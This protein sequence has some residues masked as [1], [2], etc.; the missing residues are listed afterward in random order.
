MTVEAILFQEKTGINCHAA[1]GGLFQ[2]DLTV[3]S[4]RVNEI[5]VVMVSTFP[6]IGFTENN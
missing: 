4:V 2:T 5:H 3:Y 1:F 6:G